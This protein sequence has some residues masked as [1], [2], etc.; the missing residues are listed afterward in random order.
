MI[1]PTDKRTPSTILSVIHI[2]SLAPYRTFARVDADDG[3]SLFPLS[4]DSLQAKEQDL[5]EGGERS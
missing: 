5:E 3:V 4:V 2:S 1:R